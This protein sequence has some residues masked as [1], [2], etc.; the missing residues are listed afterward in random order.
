[1]KIPHLP[2]LVVLAGCAEPLSLYGEE[3]DFSTI[4]PPP[5]ATFSESFQFTSEGAEFRMESSPINVHVLSSV[6][7][8]EERDTEVLTPDRHSITITSQSD[9][10]TREV[11]GREERDHSESVLVGK[12]IIAEFSQTGGWRH[13]L[14]SGSP[15][16]AER[17]ALLAMDSD[18]GTL[19][20]EAIRVGDVWTARA[21]EVLGSFGSFAGGE[22]IVSGTATMRASQVLSYDGHPCLEIEMLLPD[23]TVRKDWDSEPHL[24]MDLQGTSCHSLSTGLE[25]RGEGEGFFLVREMIDGMPSMELKPIQISG[26]TSLSLP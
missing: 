10:I 12:T 18:G 22:E 4:D 6:K 21:E 13:R 24:E 8:E 19:P 17:E 16:D 23:V 7:S 11:F 9:T 5:G 25:L 20:D 3:W 1:M 14:A 2:L 26:S 15:T